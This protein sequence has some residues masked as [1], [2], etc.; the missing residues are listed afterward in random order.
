LSGGDPTLSSSPDFSSPDKGRVGGVVR[1]WE[2]V[3]SSGGCLLG[4]LGKIKIGNC[5][6]KADQT[7]A[8]K[9]NIF[10]C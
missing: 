4:R 8:E 1:G 5:P 2:G 6:P 10:F 9:F 7:Q 3:I